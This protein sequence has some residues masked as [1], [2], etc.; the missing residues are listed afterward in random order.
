MSFI[1][2]SLVALVIKRCPEVLSDVLPKPYAIAFAIP[3]HRNIPM[4]KYLD[5]SCLLLFP[6]D[7][8]ITRYPEI[9][10]IVQRIFC[11]YFLAVPCH[12]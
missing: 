12:T 7:L 2:L 5:L 9:L 4:D 1:P 10:S 6:V 11:A 8:V 3:Y